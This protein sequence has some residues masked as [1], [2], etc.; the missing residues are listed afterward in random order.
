MTA[1]CV[2]SCRDVN[3]RLNLADRQPEFASLDLSG[4]TCVFEDGTYRILF[5]ADRADF[6][7]GSIIRS[8][9]VCL[10]GNK[11]GYVSLS[12]DAAGVS[13]TVEYLDNAFITRKPF[14]LH[15]DF[16]VLSFIVR[17]K[18]PGGLE[19]D[20]AYAY[21]SNVN[22]GNQVS[23]GSLSGTAG[24]AGATGAAVKKADSCFKEYFSDFLLC[25]SGEQE[26]NQNIQNFI[27]E[28]L[29]FHNTQI[30]KLLFSEASEQ[31]SSLYEG[32]RSK[33]LSAYLQQLEEVVNCYES[34][35][36]YFRTQSKHTIRYASELVSYNKVKTVSAD[37]FTWLMQNAEQLS[38]VPFA[39]GISFENKN[40]LPYRMKAERSRR[41]F[42]L[43]ENRVVLSF[44]KEVLDDARQ[45]N[46]EFEREIEEEKRIFTGLDSRLPE[47]YQA[48]ILTIKAYQIAL[49]SALLDKLRARIET[50]QELYAGYSRLFEDVTLIPVF[51]SLPLK[52]RTFCEIKP[53]ARVFEMIVQWFKY[54]DC[55]L[56][57]EHLLLQVKT[58]DKLFE[59]Y[60]L[61]YLLE[62][63]TDHGF[64]PADTEHPALRFQYPVR[65]DRF[66][67]ETDVPNTYRLTSAD[68]DTEVTLYYQP[69]IS[70]TGFFNDLN[71]YRTT[72]GSFYN[73]DFV[74]KFCSHSRHQEEYVVFD[75]KF[76]S[77]KNI[78]DYMLQDV[79]SKYSQELAYRTSTG[80]PGQPTMVWVLQGRMADAGHIYRYQNSALARTYGV[81]TSCGILAVNTL[82]HHQD[83]LWQEL[84]QR[85]PFLQ[86]DV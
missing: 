63:L 60:C 73:P 41:S 84:V 40:Y 46:T 16:V 38:A 71:L 20:S 81:V 30:D 1:T 48:T 4:C 12:A 27:K 50:L 44:L 61:Y 82:I 45:V 76:S 11:I 43:Y 39:T 32:R 35:F 31:T 19:R 62:M 9:D 8:V 85:I 36:A 47:N 42:D 13:G 80:K 28:L 75:S 51:V 29:D 79:I 55:S 33:S 5:A 26:D 53:Y 64:E 14:L 86:T 6:P 54:G 66:K 18:V 65:D 67:N 22:S 37:S 58:L 52:T 57:K 77:Q 59:Y 70:S 10:N 72:S 74:L 25:A 21:G 17:Y 15:F 49:Y 3:T 83:R 2:L 7:A 68:K 24:I 69:V 23:A 78:R 34:S 56:S